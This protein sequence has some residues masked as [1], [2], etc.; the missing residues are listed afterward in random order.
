M[1][2]GNVLD[3]A[4]VDLYRHRAG[5]GRPDHAAVRHAGDFDV[6]AEIGLGKNL[7]RDVVARKRLPDDRVVLRLLRLGFARRIERIAVFSVPVEMN[8][9][10]LPADQFGVA[11]PLR[12][13]A[14]C[15][16]DAMRHRQLI[17]GKA[18]LFR[19]H[20]DQHAPRLGGGHAHLFAAFL[21]AGR[22]GRTALIDAG[23][24]VADVQLDAGEWSIEFLRHDLPNGDRQPLSHV[25]FAE[26][27][28]DGAV[29]IDGDVGGE[30]VGRERRFGGRGILGR[31]NGLPCDRSADRDDKRAAGLEQGAAREA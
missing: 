16:D 10:E 12:R 6:G 4:F 24:G 25:H 5:D 18:E 20:L 3:R 26:V 17:G 11:Y 7:R 13:I 8:V 15:V 31:A 19:R 14:R 22:T 21:D 1:A 2:D 30:L 29:G 23:V 27:G 28:R 9:E